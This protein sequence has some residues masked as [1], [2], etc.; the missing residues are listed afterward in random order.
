MRIELDNRRLSLEERKFEFKINQA[1]NAKLLIE[2][3]FQE[4]VKDE[5]FDWKDIANI[6]ILLRQ[7][8]Q[9]IA[10]DNPKRMPTQI[11]LEEA[12]YGDLV[13]AINNYHGGFCVCAEQ[14]GY[15][16]ETQKG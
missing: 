2:T 10:G 9:S 4:E 7:Y 5:V 15:I 14:L 13:T 12:E 8:K 3:E 11:E 16:Y 1:A 6:K